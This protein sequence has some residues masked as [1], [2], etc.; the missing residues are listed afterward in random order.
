MALAR[1]PVLTPVLIE[2][3][4]PTQITV[5]MHEV[6]ERRKRLRKRETK[7]IGRFLGDHLIPV[8]LGPKGRHY[9]IDHHH[10]ALA[11]L[12][13]GIKKVLVTVIADLSMLEPDQFWIVLDHHSWV[14]PYDEDGRRVNFAQIPKTVN[15]LKDDPF[16]SLAG[17]LRR[18]G[19]FAKDTT[20]FSEFLWADFFRRRIRRRHVD[21]NFS[22]AVQQAM[23]LA[24]TQDAHYLPGWCGPS[25]S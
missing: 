7:K 22:A 20:P 11:L 4:R 17:E 21:R 6:K 13:E 15:K 8:I 19:G 9:I 24:K 18:A 5:G 16:R 10:L 2:T 14:H 25:D 3:L 1:D 23:K 12:S